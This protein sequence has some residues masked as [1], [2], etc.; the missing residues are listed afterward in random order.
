MSLATPFTA[1]ICRACRMIL[2]T[3]KIA[4]RM[5]VAVVFTAV[6][7]AQPAHAYD[8]GGRGGGSSVVVVSSC[9][10]NDCVKV[11]FVV[12]VVMTLVGWACHASRQ[13]V[14]SKSFDPAHFPMR[15][16]DIG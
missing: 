3:L 8:G 2:P 12:L 16:I 15:S 11:Y 5:S 13:A 7:C 4:T 6:F 10:S 1:L 14:R 9:N